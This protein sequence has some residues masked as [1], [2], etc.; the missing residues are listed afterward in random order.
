MAVL[1]LQ[2]GDLP[3]ASALAA[4]LGLPVIPAAEQG[5]AYHLLLL[6]EGDALSLQATG[7]GRTGPIRADFGDSGMRYRRRGGHNEL[8]GR[9]VG[10]GKRPGLTVLDGTAGLGRDGFVLADLGCRVHLYE[11]HP[12]LFELLQAGLNAARAGPDPWLADVAARMTLYPGDVTAS[13]PRALGCDVIYLDPMFPQRHK[14]AAVKKEMALFQQLL[15]EGADDA[16]SLLDWALR[17]RVARVVVK[18]PARAAS[19]A[20]VKPSHSIN[21]KAVR[22]DVHVLHALA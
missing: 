4:S 20:G 1:P 3:R 15:G 7:D 18:R 17:Q 21:G 22:F 13:R 16:D 14:S 8:L 19:L 9:A 2:H 6:V 10:V 11:R 5:V 12:L